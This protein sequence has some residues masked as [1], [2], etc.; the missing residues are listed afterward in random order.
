VAPSAHGDLVVAFLQLYKATGTAD[1]LAAA[2]A[3]G[4]RILA[5]RFQGGLFRSDPSLRR[6]LISAEEAPALLHLHAA[7]NKLDVQL[8][9]CSPGQ[10]LFDCRHDEMDEGRPTMERVFRDAK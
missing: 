9:A 1:Y 10:V 5:E 6:T 2:T 3:A 8:P 4:D 7:L